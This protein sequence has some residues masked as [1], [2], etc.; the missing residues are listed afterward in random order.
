MERASLGLTVPHPMY[1]YGA[2]RPVRIT[3]R[4]SRTSSFGAPVREQAPWAPAMQRI[5]EEAA[6]DF[7]AGERPG[8]PRLLRLQLAR[9]P[10][11]V[12]SL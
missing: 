2:Q 1:W 12:I 9:A 7:G 10:R 6:A 11:K 5:P 4:R 8:H 3:V